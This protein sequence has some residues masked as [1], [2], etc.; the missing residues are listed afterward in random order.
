MGHFVYQ[1]IFDNDLVPFNLENLK[2][3][4]LSDYNDPFSSSDFI[5]SLILNTKTYD[6]LFDNTKLSSYIAP[7]LD[8]EKA[9]RAPVEL[10]TEM[11]GLNSK[12]LNNFKFS[13]E[14]IE[15]L[16]QNSYIDLFLMISL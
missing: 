6:L 14:Y 15:Y 7:Y 9:A 16:K 8:Y 12:D 11:L 2:S 3:A 4:L 5:E 13:K 10:A 1:Q